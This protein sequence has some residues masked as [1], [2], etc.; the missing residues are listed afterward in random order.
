MDNVVSLDDY[1]RMKASR[2]EVSPKSEELELLELFSKL[3]GISPD[4]LEE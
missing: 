1:R 2:E 4:R 3:T